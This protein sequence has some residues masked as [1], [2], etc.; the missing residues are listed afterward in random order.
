VRQLELDNIVYSKPRK[1]GN[2]KIVLIGYRD[3]NL[4]DIVPLIYQTTDLYCGKTVERID[5]NDYKLDVPIYAKTNK[6]TEEFNTFLNNLN[7]KVIDDANK[8]RKLWFESD[9]IK[10]KS[11]IRKSPNVDPMFAN[12]V[13]R[14]KIKNNDRFKTHIFDEFKENVDADI[15][16][17][18]DS[19]YLKALIEISAI[20]I[21]NNSFELI[22]KIHQIGT[23]PILQ[24]V[25]NIDKYAFIDESDEDD[26][27][28]ELCIDTDV[29]PTFGSGLEPTFGSE[30]EKLNEDSVVDIVSDDFEEK[31]MKLKD[32][33]DIDDD[34]LHNIPPDQ[35]NMMCDELPDIFD[36]TSC[37]DE[38]DKLSMD[39]FI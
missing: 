38:D 13:I 30:L 23:T 6:K 15:A 39:E 19:C 31:I 25:K 20:V 2:K 24:Q 34:T 8:N 37:D 11:I 35:L 26:E 18:A 33:L 14:L 21:N 16:L 12:G 27:Y 10:Y 4:N 32:I 22:S 17:N 36:D 9:N 3:P 1:N 28:A 5:K 7:S 29:E